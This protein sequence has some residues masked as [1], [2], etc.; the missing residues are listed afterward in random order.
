MKGKNLHLLGAFFPFESIPVFR[1]DLVCGKAKQE[2][3]T[4]VISL[5]KIAEN[6]PSLYDPLNTN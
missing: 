3:T 6:L 2:V 4:K 5:V 1:G